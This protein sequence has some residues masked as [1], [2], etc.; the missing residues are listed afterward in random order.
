MNVLTENRVGRIIYSHQDLVENQDQLFIIM[1]KLIVTKVL[2]K[3]YS[4]SYELTAF[5]E[6]FRPLANGELIPLYSVTIANGVV[7]FIE[8]EEEE[9]EL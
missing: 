4:A 2:Y 6:G 8:L 5:C 9:E 1:G 7:E 3:L